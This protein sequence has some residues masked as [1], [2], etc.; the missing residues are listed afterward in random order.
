MIDKLKEEI[1]DKKAELKALEG[2]LL[3]IQSEEYIRIFGVSLKFGDT[4][5]TPEK[6]AIREAF[7]KGKIDKYEFVDRSEKYIKDRGLAKAAGP[8]PYLKEVIGKKMIDKLKEEIENK[9]AELQALEAELNNE[10]E[11]SKNA[12]WPKKGDLCYGVTEYGNG[13][14][15]DH[16]SDLPPLDPVFKTEE[17]AELY[18]KIVRRV[19]ELIGD[20][21]A[22]WGDGDQAKWYI[23]FFHGILEDG[24]SNYIAMIEASGLKA[25]GV[26]YMTE[27]AAQ[28]LIKE[29]GDDLKIWINGGDAT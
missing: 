6:E 21:K 16:A 17:R 28:A 13:L 24:S 19:Q 7:I 18:L 12:R 4:P 3:C 8:Y 15:L 29:F 26:T 10:L 25:Q 9:K 11:A 1:E 2:E 27:E 14:S 23:G 5:S 20:W 22:D